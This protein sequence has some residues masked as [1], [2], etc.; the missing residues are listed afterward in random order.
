MQQST[1]ISVR[2][3]NCD[4][5]IYLVCTNFVTLYFITVPQVP[6]QANLTATICGR[7]VLAGSQIFY[8]QEIGMNS[9]KNFIPE[10]HKRTPTEVESGV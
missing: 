9:D 6:Y 7:N 8:T 5:L 4:K 10:S 2:H 3:K 1:I